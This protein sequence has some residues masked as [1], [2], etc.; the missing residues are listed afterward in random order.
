MNAD[1]SV[2]G[3]PFVVRHRILLLFVIAVAVL[4]VFGIGDDVNTKLLDRL[5]E[6]TG[7]DNAEVA[8]TQGWLAVREQRYDVAA[9]AFQ[10]ALAAEPSAETAVL[11]AVTLSTQGKR[12]EAMASLEQWRTQYPD[13]LALLAM[14]A[15]G[16][17]ASE[18]AK[19]AAKL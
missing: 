7:G 4:G 18:P 10:R 5:A 11:L 8:Q 13:D 12:D 17:V 3:L 19:A 2:L 6:E 14:L 16:Y 9:A 1:T 15:Q